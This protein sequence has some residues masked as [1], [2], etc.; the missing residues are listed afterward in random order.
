MTQLFN[1][2]SLVTSNNVSHLNISNENFLPARKELY[3]FPINSH[4]H[5]LASREFYFLRETPV[6]WQVFEFWSER[7]SQK[8][9]NWISC[10][11]MN[12]QFSTLKEWRRSKS[13]STEKV[14]LK[15]KRKMIENTKVWVHCTRVQEN[16]NKIT[17][18]SLQW[19][20]QGDRTAPLPQHPPSAT[21]SRILESHFGL[22]A[23]SSA[24][25]TNMK[26]EYWEKTPMKVLFRMR[27]Y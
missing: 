22:G 14:F 21:L 2:P 11:H 17:L 13:F 16:D 4:K 5:N 1:T 9:V 26:I 12:Y 15:W 7:F 6:K 23:E 27:C 8:D 24:E 19:H 18:S 3:Q 20:S 10:T 25:S